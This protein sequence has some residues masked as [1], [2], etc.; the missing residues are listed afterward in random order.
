[1]V[2]DD[3][4][5]LYEIPVKVLNQAVKRNRSRFPGDFMFQLTAEES[6]S[7]RSHFV[8]LKTGRGRHRKYLPF[9]FT[10]Q[11]VAML[12]SVLRSKRA[13]QVNIEIMRAFVRLRQMLASNAQLARKLADLEK[14]YDAQFKVVFEAIRQLM[15]PP[16]PKKRKIGFLVEEKAAAYGRK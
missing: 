10:E 6:D 11:G 9:A 13:V 5:E 7:L 12:S 1:M 15:A 8:T 16:Q 14:K 4:A 2:D 3:L